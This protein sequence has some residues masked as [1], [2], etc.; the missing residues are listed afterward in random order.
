MTPPPPQPPNDSAS[1][2]FNSQ[3]AQLLT[4]SYRESEHLENAEQ[5][6]TSYSAAAS[7]SAS[8]PNANNSNSASPRPFNFR[9]RQCAIVECETRPYRA[10]LD[11]LSKS[12]KCGI[13]S[14]PSFPHFDDLL[15]WGKSCFALFPHFNNPSK[16]GI[17]LS[18]YFCLSCTLVDSRLYITIISMLLGRRLAL[19]AYTAPLGGRS[20]V[21]ASCSRLEF[22]IC[23]TR[24]L[25]S[26]LKST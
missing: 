26:P 3:L 8:P 20:P 2:Q 24:Y 16:C 23:S 4:A 11:R 25:F 18:Y 15:K 9:S 22:D 10:K 7:Y 21:I 5:L 12:S 1:G 17:M 19:I 6:F 14:F 13:T